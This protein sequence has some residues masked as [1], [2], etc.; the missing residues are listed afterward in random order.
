MDSNELSRQIT[1]D[2]AKAMVI[3]AQVG[4]VAA[5][6]SEL[7]GTGRSERGDVTVVVDS[8]GIVLD[9]QFSRGVAQ[10]DHEKLG[11]LVTKTTQAAI[12]DLREKGAPI[13]AKLAVAPESLL[14]GDERLEM[15]DDLLAQVRTGKAE[16][17][18]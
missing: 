5:E 13:Q 9:V 6:L 2:L 18:V 11:P 12:A 14:H 15:F 3:S 8:R 10:L 7:T 4:E 17:E 1:D 16:R